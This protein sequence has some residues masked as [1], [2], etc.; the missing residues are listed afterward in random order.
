VIQG[1]DISAESVSVCLIC[2]HTVIGEP[3]DRCPVCAASRA[4]HHPFVWP[5]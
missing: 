1:N 4:F 3:P 5:E 2:G